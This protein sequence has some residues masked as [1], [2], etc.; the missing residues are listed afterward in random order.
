M[1]DTGE[2][3]RVSVC[4]WGFYTILC[5]GGDSESDSEWKWKCRGV[6]DR[7]RIVVRVDRG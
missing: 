7:S 2:S 4:V 3:L 6:Q 1:E 5:K